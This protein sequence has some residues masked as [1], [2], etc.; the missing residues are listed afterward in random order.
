MTGCCSSSRG[1]RKTAALTG[2]GAGWAQI[3]SLDD[4]S[5]RT[6]IWQRVAAAEDPGSTVQVTGGDEPSKGALVLAVYRGT[7]TIGPFAT[8]TGAV[9]EGTTEQHA[10]PVVSAPAGALRVSFWA[11]RSSSEAG[12]TAPSGEIVRV[13]SAG[14]GGGRI[15]VLLTDPGEP[16]DGGS[17][18][19]LTAVA[20]SPSNKATSWTLLLRPAQ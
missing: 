3:D 2:P 14:T 15:G 5:L 20:A 8:A 11:D 10:T 13:L 16:V 19:G 6:T 7:S 4:G 17:T 1:A 18:G 9:T 12:W